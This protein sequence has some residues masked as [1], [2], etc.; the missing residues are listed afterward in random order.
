M[1]HSTLGVPDL[2]HAGAAPV[3]AADTAFPLSFAMLAGGFGPR[4]FRPIEK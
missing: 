4:G 3:C 1:P 2:R